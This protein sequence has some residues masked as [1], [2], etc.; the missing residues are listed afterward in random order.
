M[1]KVIDIV[2]NNSITGVKYGLK[3]VA[4]PVVEIK[5]TNKANATIG[6]HNKAKQKIQTVKLRSRNKTK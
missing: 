4:Q 1:V 5:R 3:E 2:E 6:T